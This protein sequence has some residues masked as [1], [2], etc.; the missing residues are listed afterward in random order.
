MNTG[1]QEFIKINRAQKSLF[2]VPLLLCFKIFLSLYYYTGLWI[3]ILKFFRMILDVLEGKISW[4]LEICLFR[5]HIQFFFYLMLIFLLKLLVFIENLWFVGHIEKNITQ[6][7]T[8]WAY[9]N[10]LFNS[11]L[12]FYETMGN[13][14]IKFCIC[15]FFS[16]IFL[17][18]T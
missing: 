5:G 1:L 8:L 13:I 9:R 3:S 11:T 2:R 14:F 16:R 12:T 10:F 6:A 4:N 17:F 15:P 7:D 18:Y